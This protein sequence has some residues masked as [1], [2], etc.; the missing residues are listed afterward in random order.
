MTLFS[1]LSFWVLTLPIITLI[2][3]LTVVQFNGHQQAGPRWDTPP[4]ICC[5]IWNPQQDELQ[6]RRSG[7]RWITHFCPLSWQKGR[8]GFSATSSHNW[9][10]LHLQELAG[11]LR[12]TGLLNQSIETT[13]HKRHLESLSM[14]QLSLFLPP[15]KF[16]VETMLFSSM[17]ISLFKRNPPKH[18]MLK[19]ENPE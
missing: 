12:T 6:P 17:A 14:L 13:R 4:W 15:N 9:F 8:V 2:I 10:I 18:L 11:S 16:F 5:F 1:S 3:V 7:Q 19:G